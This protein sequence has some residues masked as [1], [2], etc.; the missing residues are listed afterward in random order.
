MGRG[1][2]NG[3]KDGVGKEGMGMG[4]RSGHS[5][6][7][8]SRRKRGKKG[9]RGLDMGKSREGRERKGKSREGEKEMEEG[10]G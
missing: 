7:C 3:R 10:E 1:R 2:E 4:T 6:G 5:K 9:G 8:W